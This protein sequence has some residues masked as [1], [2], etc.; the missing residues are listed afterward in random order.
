ML[1][2]SKQTRAE[3]R[4]ELSYLFKNEYVLLKTINCCDDTY[5]IQSRGRGEDRF[6]AQLGKR[7]CTAGTVV[8][9]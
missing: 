7:V 1:C 2:H 9:P 6:I 5:V 3:E 4:R 8:A